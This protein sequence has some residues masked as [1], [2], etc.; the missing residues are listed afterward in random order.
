M[1]ADDPSS[2]PRLLSQ[3]ILNEPWLL[4]LAICTNEAC[5]AGPPTSAAD[6]SNWNCDWLVDCLDQGLQVSTVSDELLD[7]WRVAAERTRSLVA[8]TQS[9]GANET[10]CTP[11]DRLGRLAYFSECLSWFHDSDSSRVVAHDGEDERALGDVVPAWV[12]GL[13]EQLH[14]AKP[15]DDEIV[16]KMQRWRARL[17]E[18]ESTAGWRGGRLAPF[19]IQTD[20]Q[21]LEFVETVRRMATRYR[22]RCDLEQ[23]FSEAVEQE[24]LQAMKELAYGASHEVNNPLANIATRAQTLLR[25]ETNADRRR[26]LATINAQAFRAHEMISDMMLFARPPRLE[27]QQSNIGDLAQTVLDELQREA[28]EQQTV[29]ELDSESDVVSAIDPTH[30]GAALRAIC[31]N[32]LEALRSDGH[33]RVRVRKAPL[34]GLTETVAVEV[35]D[36][37]PGIPDEVRPRIFEPYFSGREAGRGL[38]L[39][40]S[41]AWAVV[42]EHGGRVEVS[43]VSPH[44]TKMTILLPQGERAQ[45]DTA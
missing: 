5:L 43:K 8:H 40:L 22:K 23:R 21:V 20:D 26:S 3:V 18:N 16:A 2:T 39:G 27:K 36:N 6:L 1:M 35:A 30:L 4:G 9:L 45:S 15:D 28:D 13:V 29:M 24:K 19:A 42:R 10:A 34:D 41:K 44:G 12:F 37:G 11:F 17:L 38:G 25:N 31:L 33:I 32:S 14:A 7:S